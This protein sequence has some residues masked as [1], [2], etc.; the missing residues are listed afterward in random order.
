MTGGGAW[1]LH[2]A[3]FQAALDGR[4]QA[5]PLTSAHFLLVHRRLLWAFPP[6]ARGEAPAIEEGTSKRGQP[7][8]AAVEWHN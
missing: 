7:R 8:L 1:R 3:V 2:Q 6:R 5:H 4:G